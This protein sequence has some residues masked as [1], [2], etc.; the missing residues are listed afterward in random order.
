MEEKPFSSGYVAIVGEPNAGKST[1]LNAIL[2]Q[3]LCIVSPKIQTT[4]HRILGIYTNEQCQIIFSDTPGVLEP[5]YE[6]HHA[7]MRFVEETLK[8]SDV[9]LWLI[10]GELPIVASSFGESIQKMKIPHLILLNKIDSLSEEVLETK[11]HELHTLYPEAEILPISGL[12]QFNTD[13]L[14]KKLAQLLPEGPIYFPEDQV[15][16]RNQRF[17]VSEIIREKIFLRYEKEIPY[18]VEVIV[19]DYTTDEAKNIVYI[20]AE[21]ITMR[22]SQKR[23]LIG[24]EGKSIKQIGIVARQEIERLIEQKVMLKLLVKVE[25][26]WRNKKHTLKGFGYE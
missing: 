4:R 25:P 23:I 17:F 12:H 7:M 16:D 6:L 19:S 15:T 1:L 8:D 14:L 26:D 11:I 10:D 18:S 21:I 9:V 5:K 13:V 22:E 2:K 20:Q 24:H 3:K